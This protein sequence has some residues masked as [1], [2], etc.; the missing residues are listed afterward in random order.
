MTTGYAMSLDTA[1]RFFKLCLERE[2]VTQA[3][4]LHILHELFMEDKALPMTDL[5]VKLLARD[6][7]KK[8]GEVVM[9]KGR[10]PKRKGGSL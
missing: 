3:E 9:I 6:I 4:R 1:E 5:D 7:K 2:A 8:G 10:A